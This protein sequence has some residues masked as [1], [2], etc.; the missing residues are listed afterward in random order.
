[1]PNP[2]DTTATVGFFFTARVG[3][4]YLQRKCLACF[5]WPNVATQLPGQIA[6][7]PGRRLD[8]VKFATAGLVVLVPDQA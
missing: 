4:S 8:D 5:D 3:L 7:V 1:M 2:N 6:P